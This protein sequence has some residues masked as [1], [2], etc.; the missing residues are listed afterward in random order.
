MNFNPFSFVKKVVRRLGLDP[1]QGPYFFH[2]PNARSAKGSMVALAAV[3][4]LVMAV[5]TPV[6]MTL[7]ANVRRSSTE[8]Q[9]YVAGAQNAAKAGLED[10]LGWFVRQN[11]TLTAFSSNILVGTPTAYAVSAYNASPTPTPI[12]YTYVDAP[13]NP[14]YNE[15]N[16]AFSDTAESVTNNTTDAITAYFSGICNEF[17]VDAT[18]TTIPAAGTT[19]A[20][21]FGRYEVAG[22][23][24][25]AAVAYAVHDITG[26]RQPGYVNGDGLVW[27]VNSTGYIYQRKDYRMDKYG[28]WLIPYN[29]YP[30]KVLATAK[31]YTEFRK[32]S[33][34]LPN[35]AAGD[36]ALYVA[37]GANVKLGGYAYLNGKQ[38]GAY[39]LCAMS[40]AVTKP[41]GAATTN[42]FGAGTIMGYAN[43]SAITDTS[44]FGM[45]IKD[46]QFIADNVGSA[47]STVTVGTNQL[48]YYNGDLN[49]SGSSVTT[50][51]Q[52]LNGSGILIVNG[53]L[54]MNGASP[55]TNC[56]FAGIVFCTGNL[57]I[58]NGADIDGVVIMG[59]SNG[60]A[61]GGSVDITGSAGQYG[62]LNANP[63]EV[64]QALKYVAQYRE[65]ISARRV[66]LAFPG[67]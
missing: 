24:T 33:C 53:N 54:T 39:A 63:F 22:Q 56:Y 65:D 50:A 17:T 21:Y 1:E 10:T 27:A 16:P 5:L 36:A 6:A 25:T 61:A 57:T 31:A 44:V 20:S 30:N 55:A 67:I 47:S 38:S 8:A 45:S 29:T 18:S 49:Y 9:L 52:N 26:N 59:Y 35:S 7:V 40:G 11:K 2:I 62:I 41:T 34:N 3:F 14:A 23:P 66:L 32:L 46:I 60:V 4:M 13:F 51:Y 58:T 37:N 15:T 19:A 12:Y 28:A 43:N 64:T 42:F 48:T